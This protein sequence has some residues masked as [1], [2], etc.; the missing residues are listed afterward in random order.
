LSLFVRFYD[1]LPRVWRVVRAPSLVVLGALVGFG[2]P[3]LVRL[4]QLVSQSFAELR[5]DIPSRVYARPLR[6]APKQPLSDEALLLELE[7]ARYREEQLP[8]HPGP[9]GRTVAAGRSPRARSRAPTAPGPSA[10]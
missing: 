7:A 5:F 2:I 8:I 6:L 9:T 3:Y 4:D 10:T 1:A